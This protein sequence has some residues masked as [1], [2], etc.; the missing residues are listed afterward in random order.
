[1]QSFES[2]WKIIQFDIIN[3]I[4]VSVHTQAITT[5]MPHQQLLFKLL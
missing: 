5:H 4:L 3:L 1:M 2:V